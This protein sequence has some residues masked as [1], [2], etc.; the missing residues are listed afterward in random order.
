MPTADVIP[1]C[2]D[3]GFQSSVKLTEAIGYFRDTPETGM[4]CIVN[5]PGAALIGDDAR[6]IAQRAW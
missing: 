2:P 6:A 3:V 1:M 4:P 5:S